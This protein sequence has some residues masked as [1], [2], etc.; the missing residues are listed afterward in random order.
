MVRPGH[1]AGVGVF[2]AALAGIGYAQSERSSAVG[3]PPAPWVSRA[4]PEARGEIKILP[5]GKKAQVRY[6]RAPFTQ[7]P[8]DWS[9]F[10][11]YAHDDARPAPPVRTLPLH[12]GWDLVFSAK[13]PAAV[14]PFHE[15]NRAVVDLLGRAGILPTEM[16]RKTSG[17]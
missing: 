16:P 2:L 12:P 10:R 15:L 17:T 9:D 7:V 1:L 8:Q 6:R 13:V 3:L 4:I 11:T 14:A 5:D